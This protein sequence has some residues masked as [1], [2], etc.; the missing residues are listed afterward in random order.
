MKLLAYSK[1]D[2]VPVLCGPAQLAFL[3]AFFAVFP[4]APWWVL[5]SMGLIYSVSISWNINGISHNFLHNPYFTSHTL[6]RIFS[7]IESLAIGFSQ[8]FYE[9]VHQRHHMGNSDRQDEKGETVDWLSIY[10]HGHDGEAENPWT[11]V[12]FSYFRDDP[13]AIYREIYR[14]NPADALW[15]VFE[16]AAF[17]GFYALGFFLNWKFML[18]FLPFYYF[19]HCLSYL[20]GYYLHYGGNPDKP[21]AWGVSSYHKLYNWLWFNNGYHAEHHFRPKMHWTQMAAFHR[22]IAEEQRREGV[23]VIQPP[24]ALGFLD[25]SLPK[26]S[27]PLEPELE[28]MLPAATSENS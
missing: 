4:V 26:T 14:R 16:I 1:W 12:F 25:P 27:R 23:R 15:G 17:V 10:R 21:I 22:K 7:L 20:N 6:N 3:L 19:G 24:H 8:T 5:V 13:K 28:P 18:F 9:C 11:Y 2:I